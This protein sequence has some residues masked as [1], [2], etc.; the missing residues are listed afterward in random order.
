[1]SA[2]QPKIHTCEKCGW[3]LSWRDCWNCDEDGFSDHDCGEDCC[4]CLHPE[5]NV[6]CDICNGESGWLACSMC[7]PEEE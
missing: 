3:E 4:C 6:R 1:M 5:P 7:Y 2:A